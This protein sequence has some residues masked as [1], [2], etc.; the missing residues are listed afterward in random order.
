M[1]EPGKP[2]NASA[3][4]PEGK[5]RGATRNESAGRA[6]R[7]DSRGNLEIGQSAAQTERRF[8]ATRRFT[9]GAAGRCGNRGNSR[10]HWEAFTGA[11]IRGNLKTRGDERQR[12]REARQLNSRLPATANADAGG[13][14]TR[15]PI[16]R[17]TGD[18]DAVFDKDIRKTPG[19]QVSGVFA[20]PA[21]HRTSHL[22]WA[23]ALL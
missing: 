4:T 22:S 18:D 5:L 8:E 9:A 11:G 13:G 14:E 2:G 20:F 17:L 21:L 23:V 16:Q 15:S 10:T 1:Q 19:T 7:H 3:A 12:T 6:E